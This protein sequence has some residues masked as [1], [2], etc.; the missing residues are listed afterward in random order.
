MRRLLVTKMSLMQINFKHYM[1]SRG[2][3]NAV[4]DALDQTCKVVK[5]PK[6]VEV[7]VVFIGD[8]KMREL[9]QLY[10]NKDKVSNVLS[11]PAETRRLVNSLTSQFEL[12]NQQINKLT[13]TDLGNIFICF[14]EARREA[15]KYGMTLQFEIARLAVHGLLHLLGYDH[16]SKKDE[17]EME[18]IE[19]RILKNYSN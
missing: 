11:F 19:E 2:Y 17:R 15:K 13:I 4:K 1:S 18:G 12:T 16:I 6:N 3:V 14:P 9:N 5:C 8:K 7:A 10:R